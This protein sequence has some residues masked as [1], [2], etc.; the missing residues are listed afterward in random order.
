ME[1]ASSVA[2][3]L[4]AKKMSVSFSI[5]VE[6]VSGDAVSLLFSRWRTP[7]R[8]TKRLRRKRCDHDESTGVDEFHF[9]HN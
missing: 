5:E 4:V 8:R 1:F 3:S 2:N 7:Y 6:H 9:F